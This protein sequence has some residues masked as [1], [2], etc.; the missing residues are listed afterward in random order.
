MWTYVGG[1]HE[2][3]SLVRPQGENQIAPPSL[4]DPLKQ[5]VTKADSKSAGSDVD[6]YTKISFVRFSWFCCTGSV[7]WFSSE[8]TWV[9]LNP[10][11]YQSVSESPQCDSVEGV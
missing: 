9:H 11:S 5:A 4:T 6:I 2:L 8:C 10:R 1:P 3:V 7:T